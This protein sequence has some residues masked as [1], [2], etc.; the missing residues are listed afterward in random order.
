MVKPTA[1]ALLFAVAAFNVASTVA[2]PIINSA[3]VVERAWPQE[4]GLVDQVPE[5]LTRRAAGKSTPKMTTPKPKTNASNPGK[6][7][8]P[9]KPSPGKTLPKPAPGRKTPPGKKT[10][11]TTPKPAGAPVD[12]NRL[13]GQEFA[14]EQ[15]RVGLEQQE[16]KWKPTLLQRD[17]EHH[18]TARKVPIKPKMT[19]PKPK[20]NTPNPGRKTPPKISPSN[21]TPPKVLPNNKTPPKVQLGTPKTNSAPIDQNKLLGQEF[22]LEQSR[23]G[24]EQQEEKWKPTLLQR[25]HIAARKAPITKPKMTQP[26]SKINLPNSGRKAPPKVSPGNKSS[27]P[28]PGS[29]MPPKAPLGT[30]KTNSA[31][32]DQNKL[33]GQEFALEQSRVRLEQQEEK[34][35]PT[36]LQRDE[37]Y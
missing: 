3:S 19:T 13:L 14:L 24:L 32:V 34:W 11:P 23:V 36:L 16:E 30:P 17:E 8:S 12:Q 29:K 7:P 26:G 20:T 27:K 35:K 5:E 10:P 22:A 6:K 25:D 9:A 1:S 15:S 31:P 2:V 33:L 28:L 4:R 21:R 18:Y 37:E